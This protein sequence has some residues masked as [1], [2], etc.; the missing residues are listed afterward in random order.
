[1]D[2]LQSEKALTLGAFQFRSTDDTPNRTISD[3]EKFVVYKL[4]FV[5][6]RVK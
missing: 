6:G 5:C 4:G 3:S 2:D 1:M